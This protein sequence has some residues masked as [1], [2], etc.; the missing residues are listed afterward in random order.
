MIFKYTNINDYERI[1]EEYCFDKCNKCRNCF[2][3]SMENLRIEILDKFIDIEEIPMLKCKECGYINYTEYAKDIIGGLYNELCKRGQYGVRSKANGYRKKYNYATNNNFIYDHR[4]YESIPGLKYDEEHSEEGFLTPVYFDRKALLYFIS[5]T[6]YEVDIFSE[7]YGNICKKDAEGIYPY[8]WAVPFGFNTNGNLIFWLGDLHA[9][10]EFSRG[11]V[12]NFNVDSDHLLID[13]EFYQAQMNCIFSDPIKEKQ[14]IINKKVFINNIKNTYNIDLT[15]LNE[16]CEQYSKLV[17]RPIVFNEQSVSVVINAFDKI[18]VE[19]IS[20]KKLREL[21]ETLYE[22]CYRDKKYKEWKSIRLI[23]EILIKFINNSNG[24]MKIDIETVISPLYILH[25]YRNYS[26]HL[27][28]TDKQESIKSN[29]LK[30]LGV[31]NFSEQEK[32]YLEEVKRLDDLFKYLLI[33]SR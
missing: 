4:D 17:K 13:S 24:E 25:D 2:E 6:N 16:E 9:M 10:D 28:S 27:L 12:R 21:Y 20:I 29:I 14:I 18:L 8:E 31:N 22:E 3:I 33:L 32:I 26:D 11:L 15:H 19:G 30:T 23:K 5:D 1:F 7:T